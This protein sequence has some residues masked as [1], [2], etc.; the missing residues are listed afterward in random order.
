MAGIAP[1]PPLAEKILPSFLVCGGEG[2]GG[3][4]NFF[5]LGVSG[6]TK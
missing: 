4:E 5:I 2:E 3:D 6:K 1:V